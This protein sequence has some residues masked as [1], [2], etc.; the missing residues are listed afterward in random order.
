MQ[1]INVG[2]REFRANLPH[3]LLKMG[4]PIAVTR[5][6]TTIGY[7]IPSQVKENEQMLE[8][9]LEDAMLLVE[10][11]D[12]PVTANPKLQN[13]FKKYQQTQKF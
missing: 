13:A 7:F 9:S 4:E 6:G 11:L 2:M 1:A 10:A 12:N 5:H 3:Y 8:L